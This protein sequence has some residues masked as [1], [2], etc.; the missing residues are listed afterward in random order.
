MQAS[1][2][3]TLILKNQSQNSQ[4]KI[5]EEKLIEPLTRV[6]KQETHKPVTPQTAT[7]ENLQYLKNSLDALFP[8]QL[9]EEKEVKRTKQILGDVATEFTEDELKDTVTKI[10]FLA[11]SWLDDFE[12]NVF[13]G[14]TLKELLHE[15]GGSK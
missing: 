6:L 7:E 15:Q 12:R 2:F 8:E 4:N 14:I 5:S 11:N 9:Y 3:E 13:G 10:Q 1:L